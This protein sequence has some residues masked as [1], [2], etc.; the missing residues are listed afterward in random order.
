M[1]CQLNDI[2]SCHSYDIMLGCWNEEPS[3]RPTFSQL[4]A[5]FDALLLAERKDAYIILQVDTEKP[6]YKMD[7]SDSKE[8][9]HAASLSANRKSQLSIDVPVYDI[10]KPASSHA[11]I[12]PQGSPQPSNNFH[13]HRSPLSLSPC[14]ENSPQPPRPASM[15]LTRSE[16]PVVNP[17]VDEPSRPRTK[18]VVP[19]N[20]T[21]EVLRRR[22]SDGNIQLNGESH[23]SAP[24]IQITVSPDPE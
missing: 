4:R 14:H 8:F 18:L 17:Y 13:G 23:S 12:S 20:P 9:L 24:S 19:M 7:A 6:Y 2:L 16:Q 22:R 21:Q 15:H 10:E 3:K 5:S 11:F 1:D